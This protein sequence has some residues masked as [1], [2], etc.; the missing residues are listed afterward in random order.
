MTAALA[1]CEKHPLTELTVGEAQSILHQI[2]ILIKNPKRAP[3]PLGPA[4]TCVAC[5]RTFHTKSR[6]HDHMNE[7]LGYEPHACNERGCAESFSDR[8]ALG[9][10]MKV[11]H[12]KI[13]ACLEGDCGKVF[14]SGAI[15]K[16]HAKMHAPERPHQCLEPG[17]G[18]RFM[19]P[20]TLKQHRRVHTM[21]KNHAC[22]FAGC[23]MRFGYKV[24]LYTL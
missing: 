23:G 5:G 4:H 21:E 7:H 9:R 19:T 17:C 14:S 24:G 6:L 2:K 3:Q 13:Y 16:E 8:K 11:A 1:L 20:G 12:K 22:D 15:L 10:H 18:F